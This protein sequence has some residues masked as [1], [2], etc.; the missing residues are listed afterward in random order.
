MEELCNHNAN[1]N[2]YKKEQGEQYESKH[3]RKK[4]ILTSFVQQFK[5][6]RID[7]GGAYK[8]SLQ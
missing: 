3:K 2:A 5:R 7:K 8:V 1:M 4:I 6:K